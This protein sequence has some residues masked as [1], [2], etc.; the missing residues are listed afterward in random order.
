MPEERDEDGGDD[1]TDLLREALGHAVKAA[2]HLGKA[3][4]LMGDNL[5]ANPE[6]KATR[7]AL[8]RRALRAAAASS[9]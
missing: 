5:P 4:D 7:A 6:D 1:H 8:I 9:I 3:V 2:K